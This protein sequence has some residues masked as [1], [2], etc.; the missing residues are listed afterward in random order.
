MSHYTYS[1]LIF[2]KEDNLVGKKNTFNKCC[3][4]N[5]V[6]TYKRMNLDPLLH[7]IYKDQFKLD[8]IFNLELTMKLLEEN[9]GVNLC[10]LGLP[11]VS[12][13]WPKVQATKEKIDYLRFTTIKNSC[14]S[15]NIIKR[16]KRH[17][18]EWKKY[19]EIIYLTRDLHPKYTRNS[20]HSII[21]TNNPIF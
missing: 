13:M 19:P 3:W 4:D 17:H 14:V 15:K 18:T 20:Y 10:D 16:A 7:I 5:Q 21:K 11:V 8:Q 1:Q 2:N 12:W 9:I 6:S